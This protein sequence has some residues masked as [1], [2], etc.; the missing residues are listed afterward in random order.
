MFHGKNE[1]CSE[2]VEEGKVGFCCLFS[3]G[4]T[5]VVDEV[6]V[7]G[8]VVD[9]DDDLYQSDPCEF[10]YERRFHGSTLVLGVELRRSR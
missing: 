6:G 3:E 9:Q 5:S 2:G 4:S 7:G 8:R 10:D 1:V